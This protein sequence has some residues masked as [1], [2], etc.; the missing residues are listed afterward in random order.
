ME[1]GI[2][3][4]V[5]ILNLHP[6][7]YLYEFGSQWNSSKQIGHTFVNMK[8][9]EAEQHMDHQVLQHSKEYRVSKTLRMGCGKKYNYEVFMFFTC[10]DSS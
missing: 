6:N 2:I 1:K 9:A 10:N 8:G 3:H 7:R 5:T 4:S